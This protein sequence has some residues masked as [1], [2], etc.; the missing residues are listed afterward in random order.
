MQ[1]TVKI[2][3][4][5]GLH[6]RSAATFVQLASKFQSNVKVRKGDIEVNGKSI[7]GMMMLGA[8]SGSSITIKVAGPDE[9][10]AP[11]ELEKLIK[12]KFGEE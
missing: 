3:N 10:R 6:A 2:T 4:K 12:D 11:E 5:A 9:E 7:L 1:A 8:T